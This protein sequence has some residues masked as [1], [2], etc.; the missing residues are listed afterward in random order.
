VTWNLFDADPHF[1]PSGR[2]P[3]ARIQTLTGSTLLPSPAQ[4]GGL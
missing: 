4:G 1:R 2:F 3:V